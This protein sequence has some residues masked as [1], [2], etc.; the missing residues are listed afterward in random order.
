MPLN[1]V[2]G[3]IVGGVKANIADHSHHVLLILTDVNGNDS[4]CGGSIIKSNF[5]LSAAHC[6][7]NQMAVTVVA[8][9]DEVKNMKDAWIFR[10]ISTKNFISHKDFD[11][12]SLVNDIS[13]IRLEVPFPETK[14]ISIISLPTPAYDEKYLANKKM[15]L[16]GFGRFADKDPFLSK[17]LKTDKFLLTDLN[18][19]KTT[20][21]EH[22][23]S[24][25]QLCVKAEL[26]SS[27]CMGD[28]GGGLVLYE[29]KPI[30]IGIV[31]FGASVCEAGFP[32][33]FTK[34]SSYLNWIVEIT[35]IKNV[36]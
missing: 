24:D 31:S 5:V 22:P 17:F 21:Y 29:N 13:L 14:D 19:C 36:L 26:T 3:R 4:Y 7:F 12:K 10:N 35:K 6:T 20:F 32:V 18:D 33:V 11:E 28:S 34:V 23:M 27:P 1:S 16:A 30:L 9:I 8:G 15:T 2:F 25:S